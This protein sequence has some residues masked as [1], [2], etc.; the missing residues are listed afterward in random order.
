MRNSP[1]PGARL[2][3]VRRRIDRLD[4]QLVRLINRRASMALT[5]GRMKKR[6]KWPVFDAK[7]EA[8]VLRHVVSSSRGPLSHAAVRK[9]F[10]TILSQC[11]RRERR[12]HRGRTPATSARA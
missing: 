2:V 8:F 10:K 3:A 12:T 7:R 9:I 4:E 6:K 5:I 1:R 11:R